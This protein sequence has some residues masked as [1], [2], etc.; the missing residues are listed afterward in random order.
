[1]RILLKKGNF[2]YLLRHVLIFS[3]I[4]GALFR[5][6]SFFS[7]S[8][9]PRI[10]QKFFSSWG[11]EI[12]KIN[13]DAEIPSEIQ[14]KVVLKKQT[15]ECPQCVSA[16]A[17]DCEYAMES[18]L[19]GIG[20]RT[21]MCKRFGKDCALS[22]LDTT[23]RST[24]ASPVNNTYI[25]PPLGEN[26]G[27]WIEDQTHCEKYKET[28]KACFLGKFRYSAVNAL[29]SS[30]AC[31]LLESRNISRVHLVGDSLMRHLFHGLTM[32]LSGNYNEAF[33]GDQEN[34]MGAAVFKESRCR[35]PSY[36]KTVCS[37][38][39]EIQLTAHNPRKAE[40][41]QSIAQF[42]TTSPHH[43]TMVLYGVGNHP[44]STGRRYSI[45]SAELWS[46]RWSIFYKNHQRF[47]EHGQNRMFWI[48]PHYKMSIGD[49]WES[50]QRAV[51]YMQESSL[52]FGE[53]G[54]PTL[55][56]FELTEGASRYFCRNCSEDFENAKVSCDYIVRETCSPTMETW[57][58][59]HYGRD[60][61]IW[62]GQMVMAL[63][64]RELQ[65]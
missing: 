11:D 24:A 63:L 23:I 40:E 2:T 18:Y 28:T 8:R 46:S 61:N 65:K 48:P 20:N 54:V 33:R 9:N 60:I 30:E 56:T 53:R 51:Q 62:K 7:G 13:K 31:S 15:K 39:V 55:N 22:C 58:G 25:W 27:E 3:A 4:I 49:L 26:E 41:E 32:V 64:Q 21:A 14:D 43:P 6:L 35:A 45:L 5:N 36:T 1:M 59:Y 37:D 19:G 47:L 17:S 10:G 42:Q 29:S 57:D 12:G 38:Q 52:Y 44:G 16:A 50:N 34:C